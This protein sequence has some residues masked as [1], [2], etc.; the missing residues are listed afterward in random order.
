M[1]EPE[2]KHQIRLYLD[3]QDETHLTSIQEGSKTPKWPGKFTFPVYQPR[4]DEDFA[5]M[6]IDDMD[7]E[8]DD[9]IMHSTSVD[10][11]NLVKKGSGKI[12]KW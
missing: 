7:A 4:K 8:G 1:F 11:R 9:K 2:V 10:I 6:T 3:G 12:E 5:E